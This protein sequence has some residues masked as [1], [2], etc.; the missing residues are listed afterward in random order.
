MNCVKQK[1][2]ISTFSPAS[3][4][5]SLWVFLKFYENDRNWIFQTE[6]NEKPSSAHGFLSLFC[7]AVPNTWQKS[8]KSHVHMKAH[9]EIMAQKNANCNFVPTLAQD[10]LR[11]QHVHIGFIVLKCSI[12]VQ[13]HIKWGVTM[14]LCWLWPQKSIQNYKKSKYSCLKSPFLGRALVF[15][16]NVFYFIFHQSL[17]AHNEQ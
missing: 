15:D 1:S 5:D 16:Q 6:F 8:K 3:A 13:L 12:Q 7:L 14:C 17:P 4:Q 11:S 2:W 10:I 9:L